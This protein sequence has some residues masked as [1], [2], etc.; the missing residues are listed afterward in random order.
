MDV[1]DIAPFPDQSYLGST[2]MLTLPS[3]QSEQRQGFSHE[4]LTRGTVCLV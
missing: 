3:T 4:R 2:Y 1:P